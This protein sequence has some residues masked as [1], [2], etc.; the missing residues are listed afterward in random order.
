MPEILKFDSQTPTD[1]GINEVIF[2]RTIKGI[3]SLI[4]K[5]Y[6]KNES[7]ELSFRGTL[8]VVPAYGKSYSE[9]LSISS[10][11][12]LWSKKLDFELEPLGRFEIKGRTIPLTTPA[13]T[14]GRATIKISGDWI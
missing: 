10:D 9:D 8:H 6:L 13:G 14:S 2:R 3:P 5:F 1:L 12:N 4:T 11:G 7:I